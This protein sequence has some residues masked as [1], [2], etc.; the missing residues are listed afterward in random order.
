MRRVV[1]IHRHPAAARERAQRISAQGFAAE[2]YMA[3]GSR[4]FRTIR[5]NPPD[6]I[7]IDLSELPS[8]GRY[9]GAMLREQK[10]TRMIPL[11][12]LEGDPEKTPLVREMLPDVEC[13]PWGRL[14]A[15]IER[16]V[17]KAPADP[18]PPVASSR[19]LCQKLRIVAGCSVALIG[20]PA[21]VKEM[22]RPIPKGVKFQSRIGEAAVVMV[23]VKSAAALGRELPSLAAQMRSKRTLWVCWPK[24]AS[25][26][27]CDLTPDLIRSMSSPYGLVDNKVCSID[28]TWSGFALSRRA[29]IGIR[30]LV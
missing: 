28:K 1:V 26:I 8:Y 12:F 29:G 17:R 3:L 5:G 19:S 2:P 15:A 11:V 18:L 23:F 22:L 4:G 13:V 21:A 25:K 10:S 6:A 20:A 30:E 24:R 14:A 16:A 7:V 9:V 27:P